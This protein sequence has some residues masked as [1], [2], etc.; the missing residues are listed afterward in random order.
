MSHTTPSA[1]IF[2]RI[3]LL[4]LLLFALMAAAAHAADDDEALILVA[5]PQLNADAMY[6]STILL[7]KPMRD[8][9]SIGF[10]INKPTPVTLGELFPDHQPSLKVTES[11]FLGG[12]VGTNMIVALVARHES[13]GSGSIQL[14]PDLFLA[15]NAQTVDRI[16]EN[17]PEHARFFAG[18]VVWRPGELEEELK[19]GFWYEMEA[20]TALVFRKQTV[21]LWEELAQKSAISRDGI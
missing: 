3:L 20:D 21:G 4:P 8:G 10:I 5:R 7:A 19:R 14:A 13:P 1:S 12:P 11:V 6:G 2:T 16:I 18:V 9:S 15:V 17:D